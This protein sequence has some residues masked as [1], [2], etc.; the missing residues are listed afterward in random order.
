MSLE[1]ISDHTIHS[2]FVSENSRVLDVGANV[3]LFSHEMI[4]RFH[5]RCVAV[6]P[7]PRI[8]DR[9][10]TH[11]LLQKHNIAIV[12]SAGSVQFH[13]S[14]IAVASSLVRIPEGFSET[15]T[16]VGKRLED[17]VEEIGWSRID[18][19][20]MDIEG[21]EIGVIG[22][23]SDAF[24]GS[25]GQVTVEFH[26]HIGLVS[27]ADIESVIERFRRLGFLAMSRYRGCYYDTL[28]INQTLCPVS[29]VEYAWMK[30]GVLNWEGLKRRL[31]RWHEKLRAQPMH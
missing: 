16:V 1:T 23:C 17:F 13:V 20:K 10:G 31:G 15:V 30:H 2:G 26:D 6:E 28:F 4:R 11:D 27:V 8:F 29:S 14:D 5:C 9:I 18:V 19:L 3:G 12:G 21:A 7:S 22:S 24:L 25:I